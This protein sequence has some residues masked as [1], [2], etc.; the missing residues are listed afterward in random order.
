MLLSCLH[1]IPVIGIGVS[2][3]SRAVGS[4][5]ILGYARVSSGSFL[6]IRSRERFATSPPKIP[7]AGKLEVLDEVVFY[8]AELAGAVG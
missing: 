4:S 1:R 3:A 2:S 8:E 6:R 7:K 5:A